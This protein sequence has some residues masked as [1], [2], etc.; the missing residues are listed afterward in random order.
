MIFYWT[1]T[2]KELVQRSGLRKIP[3][4]A[5]QIRDPEPAS[6]FINYQESESAISDADSNSGFGFQFFLNMSI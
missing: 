1:L 4:M 6:F 3:V 5:I 2:L